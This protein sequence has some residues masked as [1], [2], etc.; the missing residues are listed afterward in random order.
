LK[1]IIQ[2]NRL[3][4]R[5]LTVTDAENFYLL[6]LDE[7]VIKY[8]GDKAF[9]SIDKA[10]EFLENYNPYKKYGYGR[11]AVID[12]SNEEFLGWC[13]LKYSEELQE[14]DLGF[15]F[16]KKYWNKGFASEAALAC[17]NHG[18]KELNLQKIVGRAMEL[19]S[20]SIRVLEKVGMKY[21]STIDFEKHIGVLYEITNSNH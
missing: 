10:K 16:F 12:K 18:F 13:G 19:N 8:T 2:T 15:R 21:I 14:V 3:Y 9:E 7:E 5:E 20:A 4:L 17:I 6:N 1:K 11:W